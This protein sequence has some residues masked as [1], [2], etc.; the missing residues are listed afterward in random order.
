M[1]LSLTDPIILTPLSPLNWYRMEGEDVMMKLAFE[2]TNQKVVWTHNNVPVVNTKSVH[3]RQN[4]LELKSLTE[5][6]NGSWIATV[7]RKNCKPTLGFHVFLISK[8][9]E[10]LATHSLHLMY[11]D[12]TPNV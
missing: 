8:S 7:T 9:S 12:F 4:S 10:L 1:L 2:G 5:M 11:N 6:M 3:I